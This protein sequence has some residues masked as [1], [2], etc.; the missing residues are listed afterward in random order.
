VFVRTLS[1]GVVQRATSGADVPSEPNAISADGSL[2][3][4]PVL[5][6]GRLVDVA[7]GDV[8][9]SSPARSNALDLTPD[10]RYLAWAEGVDL[11]RLDRTTDDLVQTT[12][13]APV[14]GAGA[15]ITSVSMDDA[16]SVVAF[17]GPDGVFTWEPVDGT[18]QHLAGT[19]TLLAELSPDGTTIARTTDLG[20]VP[21]GDVTLI[22]RASGVLT[23]IENS[24]TLGSMAW[25]TDGAWV[26]FKSA[27]QTLAGDLPNPDPRELGALE[28]YGYRLRDQKIVR[29]YHKGVWGWPTGPTINGVFT[30]TD[31]NMLN[32][33][34]DRRFEV[35]AL[36][37]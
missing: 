7:T 35:V 30:A 18:V 33:P 21:E 24:R 9:W 20:D 23:V 14:Q 34:T 32:S 10:G 17:G 29:L 6:T 19:R 2:V 3:L 36:E 13:A 25:T 22:D 11:F 12:V 5:G 26:L 4:F 8:L 16:G 1:T 28:V 15:A 31:R 27:N 37:P